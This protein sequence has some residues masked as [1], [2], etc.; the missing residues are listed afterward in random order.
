MIETVQDCL[1]WHLICADVM[2]TKKGKGLLEDMA[3]RSLGLRN[4]QLEVSEKLPQG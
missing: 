3:Y 1:L 4:I 2:W